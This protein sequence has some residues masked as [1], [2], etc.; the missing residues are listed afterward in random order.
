MEPRCALRYSSPMTNSIHEKFDAAAR[1]FAGWMRL[2]A[3]AV[4]AG[5]TFEIAG[6][7]VTLLHYGSSDPDAATVVV[8]FGEIHPEHEAIVMRGL[9]EHNLRTS[10]GRLGYF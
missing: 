3:D 2:D 10:A 1:E 7:P 9:L 6:V 5:H 8:D 4:A